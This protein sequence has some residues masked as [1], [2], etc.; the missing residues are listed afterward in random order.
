MKLSKS[1]PSTDSSLFVVFDVGKVL[2][3]L[4]SRLLVG[5]RSPVLSK[6]E[7]AIARRRTRELLPDSP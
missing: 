2:P 1:L 5:S 7:K 4:L 3:L 6:E